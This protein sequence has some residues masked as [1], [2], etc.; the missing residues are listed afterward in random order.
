L[1][2]ENAF[3]QEKNAVLSEIFAAG[4]DDAFKMVEEDRK[5]QARAEVLQLVTEIGLHLNKTE[6]LSRLIKR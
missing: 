2:I 1:D 3:S 5:D 4:R 6:I